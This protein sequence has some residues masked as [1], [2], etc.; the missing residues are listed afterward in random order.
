MLMF[1]SSVGWFLAQELRV[2]SI[3]VSEFYCDEHRY[4]GERFL[5]FAFCKDLD[6]LKEAGE[7]LRGISK[8]LKKQD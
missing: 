7:R 6:T 1:S 8:F 5:R 4:I 3:P 2:S